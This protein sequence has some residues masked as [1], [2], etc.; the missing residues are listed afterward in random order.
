MSDFIVDDAGAERR[1]Q[2]WRERGVADSRRSSRT[3]RGLL[4]V[5][6][7]AAAIVILAQLI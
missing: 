3:M 5:A 4:G 2:Q 7:V 6:Y 1:W